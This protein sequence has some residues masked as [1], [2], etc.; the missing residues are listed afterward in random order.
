MNG[1]L[2]DA[3]ELASDTEGLLL[4]LAAGLVEVS[5]ELVDVEELAPFCDIGVAF[6][7]WGVY[8]LE[9]A[10]SVSD[11]ARATGEEVTADDAIR[12]ALEFSAGGG[13]IGWRTHVSRTLDFPADW[14][15]T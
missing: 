12:V 10:R 9:N 8:E 5:V 3:L 14:L 13:A 7:G 1:E 6:A 4:D 2:A 15:P 11:D